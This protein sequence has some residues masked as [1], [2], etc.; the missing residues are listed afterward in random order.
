MA[1]AW[2]SRGSSG[3]EEGRELAELGEAHGPPTEERLLG[4]CR[5]LGPA[6]GLRI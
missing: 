3:E 4:S 2:K 1:G 5:V 6:V